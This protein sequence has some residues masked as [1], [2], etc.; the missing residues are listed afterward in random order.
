[1]SKEYEGLARQI[2]EKVGGKDNVL[3]VYHCQ[4]R[5]RF[6]LADESKADQAGLNEMDGVAKV[7]ISG[8]VFQ[9]VIGQVIYR[10]LRRKYQ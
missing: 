1:M 2:V 5:L 9:V 6:Q 3:D 4:T 8:G 7:L 10:R